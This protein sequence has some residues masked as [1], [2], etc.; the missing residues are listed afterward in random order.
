MNDKL[1]Q[2]AYRIDDDVSLAP[3]DPLE[4][5][6][7]TLPASLRCLDTLGV[8]HPGCWV[9]ATLSFLAFQFA[10]GGVDLLPGPVQAPFAVVVVDAVME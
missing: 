6:K 2:I 1:Q 5:T 7:A 4:G 9:F 3:I 8:Y 10:Q